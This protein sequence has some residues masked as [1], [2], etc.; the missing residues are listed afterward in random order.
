MNTVV[1]RGVLLFALPIIVLT[2]LVVG[3]NPATADS[4]KESLHSDADKVDDGDEVDND[5]PEKA[6]SMWELL[7]MTD[8][9]VSIP[10]SEG[11]T[12]KRIKITFNAKDA[13]PWKVG[14]VGNKPLVYETGDPRVLKAIT[15]FL[16]FPLCLAVS[17]NTHVGGGGYQVV[18]TMVVTTTKDEFTVYITKIGFQLEE[19]YQIHTAFY[20]WGL[21][22]FLDDLCVH[23]LGI[24]IPPDIMH[25]LTGECIINAEKEIL[26]QLNKQLRQD[27]EGAKK[28]ER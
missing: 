11:R 24:H 23:K 16:S 15:R 13:T 5:V 7:E 28:V 26:Q 14:F 2:A 17:E 8:G 19:Y 4:P 20:S 22:H 25:D 18:G 12:I 21:A 27:L 10:P 3:F 1:C 9:L 6:K